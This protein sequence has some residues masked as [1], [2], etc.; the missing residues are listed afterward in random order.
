MNIPALILFHHPA[1]VKK[2]VNRVPTNRS[3]R[4][5]NIAWRRVKLKYRK[6]DMNVYTWKS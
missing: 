2:T 5:K 3:R 1:Y 4:L 6:E